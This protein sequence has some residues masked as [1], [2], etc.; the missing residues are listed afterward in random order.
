MDNIIS[1]DVSLN[2]LESEVSRIRLLID[3]CIHLFPETPS[4]SKYEDEL[5]TV[6]GV[7]QMLLHNLERRVR[8]TR[9]PSHEFLGDPRENK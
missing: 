1:F 8:I 6:L 7:S 9:S 4:D 3:T 2:D 5:L